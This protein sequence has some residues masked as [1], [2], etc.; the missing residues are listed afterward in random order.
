M[1]FFVLHTLGDATLLD[2]ALHL[3][4]CSDVRVVR[5]SHIRMFAYSKFEN[6][7]RSAKST[8]YVVLFQIVMLMR[9]TQKSK[10]S[11]LQTKR[12]IFKRM[13]VTSENYLVTNFYSR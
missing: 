2:V 5:D 10:Y 8:F 4:L 9:Q 6:R 3:P 11:K 13:S 12:R 7:H 1:I